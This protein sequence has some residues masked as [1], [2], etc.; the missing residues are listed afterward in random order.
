MDANLEPRKPDPHEIQP[1]QAEE[2]QAPVDQSGVQIPDET[3]A[4]SDIEAPESIAADSVQP[5]ED[6]EE[7]EEEIVIK[8]KELPPMPAPEQVQP[9]D[10]PTEPSREDITRPA[11]SEFEPEEDITPEPET[12]QAQ[13]L[14]FEPIPTTGSRPE[15]APVEAVP[16][17]ATR[18]APEPPA[19]FT[20]RRTLA[21]FLSLLL[22]ALLGAALATAIGL[23]SG[24]LGGVEVAFFFALNVAAQMIGVALIYLFLRSLLL[25]TRNSDQLQLEAAEDRINRTLSE[26]E[27]AIQ[28]SSRQAADLI[29]QN[30]QI[31][32][33]SMQEMVEAV[34][35]ARAQLTRE[36][37]QSRLEQ[38]EDSLRLLEREEERIRAME[39]EF[40]RRL[41]ELRG[42][43]QLAR[44]RL[45]E[46]Q[47]AFRRANP[48]A[49]GPSVRRET[50][51]ENRQLNVGDQE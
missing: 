10:A 13:T 12:T 48:D 29:E 2:P 28:A 31:T 43:I 25:R 16:V 39:A 46:E 40:Q 21:L 11:A 44:S 35:Q 3:S 50:E 30:R 24:A 6:T 49:P 9:P 36:I 37:Y 15:A 14:P 47:D 8:T 4:L 18:P 17:S 33:K 5:V 32:L 27:Q 23:G 7:S 22:L 34:Q 1:S 51:D 41:G 19:D 45:Q 26:A 38:S 42:S 20:I